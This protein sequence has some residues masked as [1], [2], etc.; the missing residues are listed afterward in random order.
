MLDKLKNIYNTLIPYDKTVSAE[1]QW[2]ITNN[3]DVFGIK[4]TELQEKDLKLLLTFFK[5]YAPMIP[6]QSHKEKQWEERINNPNAAAIHFPFRFVYF[7]IS[8]QQIHAKELKD[9]LY[10]LFGKE[11]PILWENESEGILIEELEYEEEQIQFDQIIDILMADLSV[12]IHFFVGEV[13]NSNGA[14]KEQFNQIRKMGNQLFQ[15]SG[16]NVIHYIE[17]TPYLLLANLSPDD[18]DKLSRSVLMHFVQD[19]EMI[20]TLENFFTYNMNISETAKNMYMHRNSIQ[21]RIDKFMKETNINIQKFNEAITVKLAI[22]AR[23][24]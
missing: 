18:R 24:S 12:N 8:K 21:Y 6:E 5:R 22:L 1:Y 11:Y 17:A 9:A 10:T 19:K 20:E 2:F 23:F 16:R 7:T 15:I 14:I 4:N 3:H 13:L